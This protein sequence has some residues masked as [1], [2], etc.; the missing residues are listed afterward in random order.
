MPGFMDSITSVLQSPAVQELL[1]T[2]LGA[3]GGFL[4]TPRRAG[5]GGAIGSS[6]LGASQGLYQA[7]QAGYRQMLT[8]HYALMD[9]ISQ[10]NLD[11]MNALQKAYDALSPADKKA[12]PTPDI[13]ATAMSHQ[14]IDRMDAQ[15]L[16]DTL[17]QQFNTPDGKKR[18]AG[19]GFTDPSQLPYDKAAL[20]MI[21]KQISPPSAYEQASLGIEQ[22]RTKQE[23]SHEAAEESHER[24]E[25]GLERSRIGQ[26]ASTASRELALRREEEPL[27]AIA[28]PSSPS[29]YREVTRA[30]AIGQ[31]APPPA[32]MAAVVPVADP[33]SPT[34]FTYSPRAASAGKAAPA[35][36]A[37]A[38]T[39]IASKEAT[40]RKSEADTLKTMEAEYEKTNPKPIMTKVSSTAMAN[41]THGFYKSTI[42]AGVDPGSGAPLTDVVGTSSQP[43]G[44]LVS[45]GKQLG[46]VYKGKIYKLS[47]GSE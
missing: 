9:Q 41:W 13:Y 37:S 31:P 35:P 20:D 29:G 33:N 6:L 28:D 47:I 25:E 38:P 2:A 17:A 14:A 24:A 4:T 19:A 5:T 46:G 15:S 21:S 32:S 27:V 23:A 40:T 30:K 10:K 16:H 39:T 36:A 11:S 34:G 12:Y 43:D 45:N 42:S 1:P 26:E 8:K 3:A 44:T 22:E 7:Q 18:L